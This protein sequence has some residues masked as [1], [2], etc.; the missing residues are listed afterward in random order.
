MLHRAQPLALNDANELIVNFEYRVLSSQD[1][2]TKEQEEA[3]KK[4][5][6]ASNK[7]DLP[8]LHITRQILAAAKALDSLPADYLTLL[9]TPAPTDKIKQRPLLAK[10]INQYT[11][12]NTMDY[13][14]HKDLGS[15]LRRE[16]A[17]L[18]F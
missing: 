2:L 14:I 6:G 15:F 11:S 10:Y 13:F 9:S 3:V 4:E 5:F 17:W 1:A 8:N 16:L 12:R 7:G 18:V